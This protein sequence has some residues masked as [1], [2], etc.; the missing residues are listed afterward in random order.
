[1][2][3]V[4]MIRTISSNSELGKLAHTLF[5]EKRLLFRGIKSNNGNL[6]RAFKYQN[7]EVPPRRFKPS[8]FAQKEISGG[9]ISDVVCLTNSFQHAA[10]NYAGSAE[11]ACV[12]VVDREHESIKDLLAKGIE[13][14]EW[15]IG[16]EIP[17]EAIIGK[18]LLSEFGQFKMAM[19]NAAS[20]AENKPVESAWYKNTPLWR[21]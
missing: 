17:L 18:I 10:D 8:V 2:P 16:G 19:K 7:D 20:F 1:M 13:A 5:K 3:I 14:H 11:G 9:T 15:N 6:H 12:L 21:K 4:D